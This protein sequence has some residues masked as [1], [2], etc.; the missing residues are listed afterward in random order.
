M[1]K[2][3]IEKRIISELEMFLP[4]IRDLPFDEAFPIIRKEVWKIADKYDTDGANV[5]NILI[6]NFKELQNES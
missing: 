2:I 5:M 3:E 1:R 6:K 4:Q